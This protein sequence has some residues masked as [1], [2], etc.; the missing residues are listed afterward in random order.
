MDL[1][2]SSV[3]IAVTS[4]VAIAAFSEWE[5]WLNLLLG[6]WLVLAPWI[7]GFAHTRG[8]HMS[9]GADSVVA[10]LA[11]LQLWLAH[12]GDLVPS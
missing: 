3:L 6:I 4:I 7:L 12:Y 8:M 1:W 2:A 11:G 5:E 9:V 10:Y